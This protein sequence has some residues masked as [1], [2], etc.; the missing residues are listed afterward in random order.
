MDLE[1]L[2]HL[3]ETGSSRPHLL[4]V[5]GAFHGAW[6]WEEH[7]L[8]WF[9]GQGWAAHAL[10]LRGHGASDGAAGIRSFT[11]DDYAAD[12]AAVMGRI[13]AP[14]VLIGHSMGGVVSERAFH[15]RPDVA[16]LVFLAGSPLKPATSV[17]LRVLRERPL[18]LL[19]GQLTG[20]PAQ[21]REAMVPS[22]LSPDLP[23]AERAA[24]IARLDLESPRAM[25]ETFGRKPL[26]RKA[27]DTRPVLV[28]GG[29]EDWSIPLPRH[30]ELAAR[31]D[32][33]VRICPGAHDLMLDPE[34]QASA[35]AISDWLVETFAA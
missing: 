11:L 33:P 21:M 20:D 18:A 7:Y 16:G 32:A 8:P 27:G 13:G 9:A 29:R 3:P 10:S 12:V 31:Y 2:S 35:S 30:D 4:F 24:H 14:V 5:H 6:C 25:A 15:S 23:E 22:F 17:V 1:L 28:V 19:L 26:Y 34:W